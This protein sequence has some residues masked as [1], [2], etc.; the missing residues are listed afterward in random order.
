MS[1]PRAALLVCLLLVPSFAARGDEPATPR[2]VKGLLAALDTKHEPTAKL[3]RVLETL[4]GRAAFE[5]AVRAAGERRAAREVG[6]ALRRLASAPPAH[7]WAVEL[8]EWAS[9]VDLLDLPDELFEALGEVLEIPL[10][11]HGGKRRCATMVP[12]DSLR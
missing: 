3:A 5:E 9:D 8:A 6:G 11:R 1:L 12:V 7:G 2:T 4:P 10:G